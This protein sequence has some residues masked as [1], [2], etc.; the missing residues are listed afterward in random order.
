MP[1]LV[2]DTCAIKRAARGLDIERDKKTWI[3]NQRHKSQTRAQKRQ[4]NFSFRRENLGFLQKSR[5]EEKK[6]QVSSF[7]KINF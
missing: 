7:M 2:Q 5:Q 4:V 1:Q 6:K 3:S